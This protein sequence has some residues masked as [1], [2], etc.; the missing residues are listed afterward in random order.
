MKN[1]MF[2]PIVVLLF[3]SSFLYGAAE[4]SPYLQEKLLEALEENKPI[5]IMIILKDQ[6]DIEVRIRRMA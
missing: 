2:V 6:A 1:L 3:L 4:I 5:P